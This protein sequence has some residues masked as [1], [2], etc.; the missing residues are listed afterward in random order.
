[1]KLHPLT[2]YLKVFILIG[3][4]T[5]FSFPQS[6]NAPAAR[7]DSTQTDLTV[8]R[9][10]LISDLQF[11]NRETLRFND[12]LAVA[13]AKAEIADA[14]WQLDKAWAKKLLRAA[15]ELALPKA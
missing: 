2:K 1:M 12:P 6:M 5:S 10:S 11:L 15:Y 9:A 3:C 14:A 8:E 4:M 7:G 13:L